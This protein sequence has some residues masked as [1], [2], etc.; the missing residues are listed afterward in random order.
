M[1]LPHD[2]AA[3]PLD[4]ARRDYF[5]Q[6]GRRS[7]RRV[8]FAAI[9]AAIFLS[10]PLVGYVF[11]VAAPAREWVVRVEDESISMGELVAL[12]RAARLADDS[13]LAEKNPVEA[14]QWLAERE[15]LSQVA[16][17]EGLTLPA[18][19]IERA[20]WTRTMGADVPYAEAPPELRRQFDERYRVYLTTRTITAEQ[21]ERLV[22]YALYEQAVRAVLA[23]SAPRAGAQV[24]LA[25]LEVRDS[26]AAARAIALAEQGVPLDEIA[27]EVALS[28]QVTALGDD[29]WT[30]EGALLD[31]YQA[32]I[33]GVPS[34]GWSRP[35]GSENGLI[36]HYVHLREEDR[37]FGPG[38]LTLLVDTAL[39]RLI[40]RG[41]NDLDVRFN[42]ES[43]AFSWVIKQVGLIRNP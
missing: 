12:L 17:A 23:Q 19:V 5:R 37:P 33:A 24:R 31:R 32:A 3:P 39:D 7:K 9:L 28:G 14:A 15:T 13:P 43:D 30:P 18:D 34:G 1:V 40:D 21:D 26:E 42:L 41:L 27:S 8:V 35:V 22:R 16:Y 25:Q 6:R 38:A 11:T 4:S 20:V 2:Q 29:G 36:V 10:I